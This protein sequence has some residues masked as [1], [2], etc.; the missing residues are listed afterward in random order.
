MHRTTYCIAV[1]KYPY[2]PSRL[3]GGDAWRLLRKFPMTDFAPIHEKRTAI[4]N[5]H[6]DTPG[7]AFEANKVVFEKARRGKDPDQAF[8]AHGRSHEVRHETFVPQ[9]AEDRR[10]V[11]DAFSPPR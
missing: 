9:F 1:D 3:T 2:I 8:A 7:A 10:D 6:T 4:T 5:A 11:S